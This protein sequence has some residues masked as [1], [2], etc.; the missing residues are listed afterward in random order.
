MKKN[1]DIFRHT[2]LKLFIIHRPPL[3]ELLLC[4][5][6]FLPISSSALFHPRPL[7]PLFP[8]CFCHAW[9]PDSVHTINPFPLVSLYSSSLYSPP[10]LTWFSLSPWYQATAVSCISP[11][12][13]TSHISVAGF[14]AIFFPRACNPGNLS[15]EA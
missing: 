4:Q 11:S 13:P 14:S 15:L 8:P 1:K 12:K 3:K 10:P 9:C 2:K 5:P 7:L 6:G